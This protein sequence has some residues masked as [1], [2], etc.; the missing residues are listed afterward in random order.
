MNSFDIDLDFADRSAALKLIKHV[1]AM[2]EN[3]NRRVP[4]NTGVYVCDVA[5][6]PVTGLCS[7]DYQ[8]AQELG[9]IKLD[10]LN[11]SVYQKVQSPEHLD[12]LLSQTPPWHRLSEPQF[13]SKITHIHE[14]WNTLQKL[15]EP[16]TNISEMSMFLAII[17]PAKRHLI[18]KSWQEITKTVWIPPTDSSYYFK[19]SHA[20]SYGHLV[21]IDMIIEDQRE[22]V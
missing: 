19:K 14:Q 9:Y 8:K 21:A 13:V 1:P 6:D 12:L 7:W 4:H 16:I 3:R 22:Q 20:V 10:F 18:G 11:N 2:I 5:S 17:R 15:A